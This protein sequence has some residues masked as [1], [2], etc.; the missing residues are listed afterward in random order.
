MIKTCHPE[1]ELAYIRGIL[2]TLDLKGPCAEI[3]VYH[4]GTAQVIKSE[5]PEEDIY[6]MILTS[7]KNISSVTAMNTKRLFGKWFGR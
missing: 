3:G 6:S 1:D 4:G 5:R 2:Q 7:L